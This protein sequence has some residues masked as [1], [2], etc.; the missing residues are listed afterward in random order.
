MTK[1]TVTCNTSNTILGQIEDAR[2]EVCV[3]VR[4]LESHPFGHA[5]LWGVVEVT[6][7]N[8]KTRSYKTCLGGVC[9]ADLDKAVKVANSIKGVSSVYYVLD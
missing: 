1:Y 9:C 8:G 4:K 6:L 3:Q 2:R 7:K 5:F